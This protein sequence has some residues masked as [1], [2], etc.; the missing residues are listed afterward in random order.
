RCRGSAVS[1][2]CVSVAAV[3]ITVTTSSLTI[4]H[5]RRSKEQKKLIEKYKGELK[6]TSRLNIAQKEFE[7]DVQRRRNKIK[8]FEQ[9]HEVTVRT[10]DTLE[11]VIRSLMRKKKTE[12]EK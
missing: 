10:R 5:H 8:K 2:W 3:A 6:R 9:K 4:K 1:L 11:D 12:A 7:A